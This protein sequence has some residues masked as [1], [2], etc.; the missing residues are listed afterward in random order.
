MTIISYK[1]QF[2]RIK[3]YIGENTQPLYH[4]EINDKLSAGM[5]R[6]R[7]QAIKKAKKMILNSK[8]KCYMRKH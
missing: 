5:W 8:Y 3:K 2:I 4:A 7:N 1:K 6:K